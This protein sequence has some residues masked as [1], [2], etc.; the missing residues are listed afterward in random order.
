MN[1]H[2]WKKPTIFPEIHPVIST[3]TTTHYFVLGSS[4]VPVE[5]MSIGQG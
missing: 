5:T 2:L 1:H 3:S 4:L